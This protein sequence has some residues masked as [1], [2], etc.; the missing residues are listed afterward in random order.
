MA[1]KVNYL[2]NKRLLA[3][4][5]ECVERNEMTRE[6]AEAMMLLVRR[7]ATKANFCGYSYKDEMQGAALLDIAAKWDRFDCSRTQNPFA[8]FTQI[9][10]NA[11]IQF[12]KKEKRQQELRDKALVYEGL[13]PSYAYQ[14]AVRADLKRAL[15]SGD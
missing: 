10:K 4:H 6:F 7:L 13:M 15:S 5:A 8:Y 9:A 14:D 12:I 2:A 11:F 3:L 1:K